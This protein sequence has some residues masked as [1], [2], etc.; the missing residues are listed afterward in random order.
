MKDL[1]NFIQ[2]LLALAAIGFF[3]HLFVTPIICA[4]N[5][6]FIKGDFS[7]LTEAISKTFTFLQ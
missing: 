6:C 7:K 1:I 4:S 5:E 3:Y 2:M